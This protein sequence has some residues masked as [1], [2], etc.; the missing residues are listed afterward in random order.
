MK[1]KKFI[2]TV[3]EKYEEYNVAYNKKQDYS[4][5]IFGTFLLALAGLGVYRIVDVRFRILPRVAIEIFVTVSI[6][7]NIFTGFMLSDREE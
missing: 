5:L 7:L 4:F 1:D 2:D 3:E 6:A